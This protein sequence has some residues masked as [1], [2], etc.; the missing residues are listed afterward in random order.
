MKKLEYSQCSFAEA[1]ERISPR[2]VGLVVDMIR[3]M[4]TRRALEQ[5]QFMKVRAAPIV[6]KLIKSALANAAHNKG[7]TGEMTVLEAVVGSGGILKRY[8]PGSHGRASPIMRRFS[9]V[10]V[11]LGEAK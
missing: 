10:R 6:S 3:G 8:R 2:K 11:V 1:T 4:N 7:M 5:L 9:K